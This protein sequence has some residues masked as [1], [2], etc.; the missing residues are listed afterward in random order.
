MREF[1]PCWPP[2]LKEAER[3]NYRAECKLR[4]LTS[5]LDRIDPEDFDQ[6]M[7][8]IEEARKEVFETGSKFFE[9]KYLYLARQDKSM[10]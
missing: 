4:C 9:L 8:Q 1:N 7:D 10:P 6:V 2:L 5:S 3:R